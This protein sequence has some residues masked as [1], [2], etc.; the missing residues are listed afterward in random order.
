MR[1]QQYFDLA[2]SEAAIMTAASRFLAAWIVSGQVHTDNEK[3][4]M[5]RAAD[6]AIRL[7]RTVDNLV[8]AEGETSD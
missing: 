8:Q 1:E 7:S 4:Y 2:G 6:L 3:E 5:E